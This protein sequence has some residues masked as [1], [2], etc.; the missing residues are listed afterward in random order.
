MFY[1]IDCS[2]YVEPK[3][4]RKG[5]ANLWVR[6]KNLPVKYEKLIKSFYKQDILL[7]LEFYKLSNDIYAGRIKRIFLTEF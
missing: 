7:N 6:T 5:T 4:F 3:Y 1:R 2:Q